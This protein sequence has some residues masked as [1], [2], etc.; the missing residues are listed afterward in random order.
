MNESHTNNMCSMYAE[1]AMF[2]VKRFNLQSPTVGVRTSFGRARCVEV[3]S[4]ANAIISLRA[5][6]AICN[7]HDHRAKLNNVE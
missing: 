1:A 5:D 2:L 3:R 4:Y 6:E 7:E